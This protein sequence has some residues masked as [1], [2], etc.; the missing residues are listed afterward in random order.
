MCGCV[1]D[2][3]TCVDPECPIPF[4]DRAPLHGSLDCSQTHSWPRV[5][6]VSCD[7]GYELADPPVFHCAWDSTWTLEGPWPECYSRY[8]LLSVIDV[9]D[10]NLQIKNIKTH[11]F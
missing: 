9:K 10:I 1:C 4:A 7:S 11:V 2:F 3:Y 8:Q 6:R 5:C